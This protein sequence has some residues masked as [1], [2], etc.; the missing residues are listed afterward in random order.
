[1]LVDEAITPERHEHLRKLEAENKALKKAKAEASKKATIEVQ[2]VFD[3]RGR[4]KY[5]K[6]TRMPGGTK[7]SSPISESEAIKLGFKP[8]PHSKKR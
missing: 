4:P 2:L 8:T 1:M 3:T 7:H 6:I 5:R